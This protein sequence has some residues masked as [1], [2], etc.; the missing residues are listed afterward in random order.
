MKT[1]DAVLVAT[2]VGTVGI[3]LAERRHRQ[4]LALDAAGIHQQ[5]LSG[6][7]ADSEQLAL[8]APGDLTPEAF[9]RAVH[10]NR[11]ISFLSVKFRVG[12]L[13]RAA[14]R[15]QARSVMARGATRAYWARF[16]AFREQEATDSVTRTFNRIFDEEYCAA[17]DDTGS[18]PSSA[19]GRKSH[20]GG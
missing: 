13:D 2:A 18:V 3:W 8:W 15:V 7:A 4:R 14:L 6:I 19:S 16:G 1:P 9:G 20:S 17:A 5:L 10:C 11:L 12:L